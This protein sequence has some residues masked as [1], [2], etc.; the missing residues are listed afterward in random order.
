M[1]LGHLAMLTLWRIIRALPDHQLTRLPIDWHRP[2]IA[3]ISRG[4]EVGRKGS[5]NGQA[6]SSEARSAKARVKFLWKVAAN[7]SPLAGVFGSAVSFPV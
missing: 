7:A 5:Q 6:R 1:L 3:L 2:G 4:C